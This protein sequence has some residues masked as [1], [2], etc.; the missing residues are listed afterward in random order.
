MKNLPKKWR[1]KINPKSIT[2]VH[3]LQRLEDLD[4]S[5][6]LIEVYNGRN[7]L[8]HL[9]LVD[10]HTFEISRWEFLDDALKRLEENEHFFVFAQENRLLGCVWYTGDLVSSEKELVEKEKKNQ[11]SKVFIAKQLR[12]SD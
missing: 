11:V 4:N 3:L 5:R 2:V 12:E 6:N 1:R 7:K 10:D 9:L 8:E